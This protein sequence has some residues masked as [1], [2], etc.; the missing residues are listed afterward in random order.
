M[1]VKDHMTKNPVT[2]TKEASISEALDKMHQGNFHRLPV[3]DKDGKLEGFVTEGIVSESSS[4]NTTSL[5]IY[6]LNYL[7]SRTKVEDIMIRD[8]Q[9]TTENIVLEEA[10]NEMI[11]AN[12]A[13]LPVVD[14]DNKV[15]GIIT[16][17]D[18]FEAFVELM[19]YHHQ[20]TKFVIHC[21]D[22]PGELAHVARLFAENDANT[23]SLAVYHTEERGTEFVIKATGEVPVDTML[24]VLEEEGLEVTSVIQTTDDGNE[25]IYKSSV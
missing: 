12:I 13:A 22:K 20:G 3:V 14:A 1:Y 9:T 10:A 24:N 21:E 4:K 11:E 23:E 5:S 6:E 7:L 8:V 18:M 15:V 19:G 2:I 16:E 25:V 17:K